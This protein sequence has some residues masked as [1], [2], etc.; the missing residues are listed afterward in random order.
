MT[1]G[2]RFLKLWWV[3]QVLPGL[4]LMLVMAAAAAVYPAGSV[5]AG[6]GGFNLTVTMAGT[7][8]GTVT[9]VLP[10]INCFLPNASGSDCVEPDINTTV[11]LT[12]TPAS[13]STFGGWTGTGGCSGTGSCTVTMTT[14]VAVIATFNPT[15]LPEAITVSPTR[16]SPKSTTVT[17]SGTDFVAGTYNILFDNT[18][19]GSVTTGGGSWSQTFIVPATAFGSYTVT[20]GTVTANFTVDAK[21]SISPSRGP[22]GTRVTLTGEGFATGQGELPVRFGAQQVITGS[23]DS[24]GSVITRYNVPALPAGSY[25]VTI[26]NAPPVNFTITSSLSIG[27][28]SGPPGTTVSL[29]G[30]GFGANATINLTFD[31]NT[32]R[33]VST[34]NEGALSTSFQ[35]PEAP[36]GPRS[37]GVSEAGRG[38]MQTTFTITPRL[39]LDRLNSSPGSIVTATGTGFSA[40]ERAISVTM[41]QETVASGISANANGSW[42]ASLTVPS[43]PAGS[44]T[45]QASGSLT[46]RTNVPTVTLTLGAVVSLDRS[47][48]P[49][50]TSLKVS[51]SGFRS[52]DS[53]AV[54]I[55]DGLADAVVSADAQGAW[56]FDMQV[57]TTASGRIVISA[58][59]ASGR[60]IETGFTVRSAVS[61][62]QP[63]GSPGSSVTIEGTGFRANADGIS[64]KFGST[65][66]ASAS[67]NAQGAWTRT[68]TV[69]PSPAG[70]YSVDI[71]GSSTPLQVPFSVTPTISMNGSKGAPGASVTVKGSG[72]AANER[73]ITITL[74]DTPVGEGISANAEGS[75]SVSFALPSLPTGTYSVQ[76]F[77]SR[78][79]S[80]SVPEIRLTLG[81]DLRL[82]RSSA[83]PG[84]IITVSGAG[85]K[86][87]ESIT[88]TVGNGLAQATSVADGLGAWSANI[89][90]PPTVGGRLVI[91]ASGS[92]GLLIESDFT[93]T[94]TVS[95]SQPISPP[96]SIVEVKGNGFIAGQSISVSFEATT[97][98]TPLADSQGAWTASFTVPPSPAGTY[99]IAISGPAGQR[100]IPYLVTPALSLSTPRGGPTESITVSGVGFAANEK[101]ISVTLDQ[102]P[103][104]SGVSADRNGSWSTSFLV[105]SLPSAS[106]SLR[107]SGPL[108]TSGNASDEF[109]TVIPRLDISP[110]RGEPGSTVNVTGSG[111][112]S[113]QRDIVITYD[114][115][116]VALV[117]TADSSGAFSTFFTVPDSPFGLH[118]VSHSGGIGRTAGGTEAG[119]QVV[120]AISLNESNGPPETFI[121]VEGVGFAANDPGITI[122]Y[123]GA[124]VLS[125]VAADAQGS[126]S[127][128]ILAQPS[129]GGVHE[130]QASGSALTSLSYPVQNFRVT[131][132]LALSSTTGN[133]GDE[134]EV[135]GLG[136]AARTSVTLDYGD[137][138]MQV[139]AESDNSGT[140]HVDL[141]IPSSES[142]DQVIAA[143]GEED[144]RAQVTFSLDSTP[145]PPP[146]LLA[147]DN[148]ARGGLLGGFRPISEW[149]RVEDPS[150][151]TYDLQ[152]ATDSAFSAPILE[153]TGLKS[154]RYALKEQEALSR[155]KYYWRVRAVDRASNASVWSSAFVVQSG[156]IPL[157]VIPALAS[158]AV[159]LVGWTGYSV[160]NRRRR[161]R[162]Q[163]PLTELAREISAAPALPAPGSRVVPALRP[164][165]RLA[166]PAAPR[167][168]RGRSPEDQARLIL[169]LEF[170]RSLPL[171]QVSSDFTWLDELVESTGGAEAEVYEQVLEGQIELGYQPAW[172]RHP[173]Y[174]EVKR[175]L[176]GHQFLE[177]LEDFVKAVDD[178]A[179]DTVSLLR[180]VYQDIAQALPP[181]AARVHQWRFVLAVIKHSLAWYGGTYLKEP[182]AR[183]YNILPDTGAEDVVSLHG[184]EGTPFPGPLV[185][186]LSEADALAYRD[187]HLLLRTSYSNSEEAQQLTAR[188]ASLVILREQL[189]TNLAEL[190]QTP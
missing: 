41:G 127:V 66:V 135:T 179:V 78:T 19:V 118:V 185:E 164:P 181:E 178:C 120:P 81:A 40:N 5:L 24:L 145:P 131:Q 84:T 169:V 11:I 39:I 31:G 95:L 92:G 112:G 56:T 168:R 114:G 110:D 186:G 133:V 100:K 160:Y 113:S 55:G 98:A 136:F 59:G 47:S 117:V 103:V 85:F 121:I 130:I 45:V 48:G 96:G 173:T 180:Q 101:G 3:R 175:I 141:L 190:D 15:A 25:S 86:Q 46:S 97:V 142:G 132:S 67:A 162:T 14:T 106:Y 111:F 54:T 1:T 68:F 163:A 151:V 157:W 65:V 144:F 80:S 152:I 128:S 72:F 75:W 16:G 35:V 123:D 154:P 172:A 10:G 188:M 53:V 149:G 94:S 115:T 64:I 159:I 20:V 174:E 126:F 105:P 17:V 187:V 122:T 189:T 4:L 137:G 146:G 12:A 36:R 140:F 29:S 82:D 13:G 30:S 26:G 21:F 99:S 165:A 7:G 167:R 50:G 171:L 119:F 108:T 147:P 73:D 79:S 37:V 93:V 58:T 76:G 139:T 18:T 156:I 34:D 8:G 61:L 70:T 166:L 107:A 60:S 2:S 38:A 23:V 158:L 44:H 129:P 32:I 51:G 9:S 90:I 33:S 63:S 83:P 71:S 28:S 52:R 116:S 57:P 176:Q 170:L 42:S 138:L 184:E 153:I 143:V 87:R 148:G 43:L 150:G 102:T 77:G 27:T 125:A 6:H 161:W 124:T 134:V 183:D 88:I 177:G 91:H 155:G 69:P 89:T 49:P 182:S 22:V 62:S 104:A 109:L 74:D